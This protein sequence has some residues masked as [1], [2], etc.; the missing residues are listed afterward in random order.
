[1]RQVRVLG[2]RQ[3]AEDIGYAVQGLNEGADNFDVEEW[4]E[5]LYCLKGL[6]QVV[7]FSAGAVKRV[8]GRGC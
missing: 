5:M 6:K 8:H 7:R 3:V 4:Q 1:M 2:D